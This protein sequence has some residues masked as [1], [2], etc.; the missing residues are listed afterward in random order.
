MRAVAVALLLLAPACGSPVAPTSSAS[1]APTYDG[2]PGQRYRA[3]VTILESPDNG[4]PE[5]CVGVIADSLP[6]QCGGIPLAP[7]SWADVE[8]EQSASGTTWADSVRVVGTFDGTTFHLTEKAAAVPRP[9]PSP[10]PAFESPCPEPSEGDPSMTS[11]PERDAAI[12]HARSQ[13]DHAGVWLSGRVLNLA[14]TGDLERHE[15]EAR[16]SWGGPLCVTRL[17]RTYASLQR[18]SDR[19]VSDDERKAA[20]AAGVYVYSGGV[21][22]VENDVEVGVLIAD[23]EVRRWFDS[24]YGAGVVHLSPMLEP[25]P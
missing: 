18:T 11:E 15:R 8:G 7:F 3:V 16:S 17:P 1:P 14:F 23:D 2:G 25:V 5:I 24:R 9:T 22:E 19:I 21:R 20:E 12:A 4:R 10:G 13:P 6:P